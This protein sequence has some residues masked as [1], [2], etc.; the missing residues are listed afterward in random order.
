MAAPIP[1]G[2][3]PVE[4]LERL[5]AALEPRDDVLLGPG[6]GED[7]C[8]LAVGGGALIAATDP[9]TLTT[10]DL[11]R[12]AVVVNA[13]DVAVCGAR[14]RWFLAVVLL[15]PDTTAA[16]VEELFASMRVAL[17]E[18]GAVLVGGHTE[19]TSAVNQPVIVGHMLGFA[20]DGKFVTTGGARPGDAVV[21]VGLAPVEGTAVL[22]TAAAPRLDHVSPDVVDAAR[23]AITDP[24]ISVVEAA[25]RAAALGA[26][27]LHD[28]TEGGLAS[29]LN[30]VALAAG[31]R[32]RVTRA[33][34]QWFG[35]GVQVCA[36]LGA[37][38]WATLASG[39]LLATF[40]AD[41]V[42]EA[43]HALVAARH[44][45]ARIGVVETGSG[46]VDTDGA[47]IPT[48]DRDELARLLS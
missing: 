35:P 10:S 32:L 2:K 47:I 44:V 33:A 27:A 17:D 45:V 4:L 38:P 14:P 25:L 16:A 9:I 19:V 18:V 40:P 26:T 39:A 20:P 12:Y 5:L 28:P 8:A 6:V 42:D 24:G 1:V 31:A 48:P 22:A 23:N 34:I 11:G 36:A 46:V 15:P 3:L 29:G 30:E 13:N 21:Q 7:A 37:D 41:L 43:V